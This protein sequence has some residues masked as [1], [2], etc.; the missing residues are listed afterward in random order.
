M[1]EQRRS[2]M[3]EPSQP[4]VQDLVGTIMRHA[5][6]YHL[7]AT[8]VLLACAYVAGNIFGLFAYQHPPLREEKYRMFMDY[9]GEVER[10]QTLAQA[11]E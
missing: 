6:E 1:A 11:E 2:E 7:P 5:E 3:S 10:K 9:L 8:D 4:N